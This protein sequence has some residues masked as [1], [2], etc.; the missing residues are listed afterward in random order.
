MDDDIPPPPPPLEDGTCTIDRQKSNRVIAGLISAAWLALF[1]AQYIGLSKHMKSGAEPIGQILLMTIATI[2]MVLFFIFAINDSILAKGTPT[3][4]F[5]F[6]VILHVAF[7]IIW[8]L[9]STWLDDDS[10]WQSWSNMNEWGRFN[11][12][13]IPVITG[14]SLLTLLIYK[15]FKTKTVIISI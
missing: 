1:V 15:Y 6:F 4:V 3:F 8:F 14:V 5:I 13:G 12:V 10:K 9:S 11:A 7:L 2:L